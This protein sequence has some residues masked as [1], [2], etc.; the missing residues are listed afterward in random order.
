VVLN[1]IL[2]ND[3]GL[4]TGVRRQESGASRSC[5]VH[6]QDPRGS[7]G[8]TGRGQA[9]EPEDDGFTSLLASAIPAATG[10]RSTS[11][12]CNAHSLPVGRRAKA[13]PVSVST[14]EFPEHRRIARTAVGGQTAALA[15]PRS[16]YISRSFVR[17][18]IK[19]REPDKTP[20]PLHR[21]NTPI[22]RCIKELGDYPQRQVTRG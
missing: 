7:C 3:F 22:L 12:K 8:C 18:H 14:R 9:F 19:R 11:S 16:L 4:E 10:C 13:P 20:C 6:S 17:L 21:E 5:C 1:S 15:R 2:P